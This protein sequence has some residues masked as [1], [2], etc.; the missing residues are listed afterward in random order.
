MNVN[1]IVSLANNDF[2]R[3]N[4]YKLLL[5]APPALQG[6]YNNS[7]MDLINSNC[8]TINI[9]GT[10]I[11]TFD[12]ANKS[13]PIKL[14]YQRVYNP[15]VLTFYNDS[16]GIV[17]QFFEDWINLMWNPETYDFNYRDEYGVEF[18]MELLDMKN[19]KKLVFTVDHAWPM[20]IDDIPLAYADSEIQKV[21]ATIT[22][23]IYKLQKI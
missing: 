15:L 7:V 8:N 9:P 19:D 23:N 6:K 4:R 21:T 12:W 10:D 14:P 20:K 1:K 3:S 22:Y 13:A 18:T 17:R 2:L 5:V 16:E 11:A